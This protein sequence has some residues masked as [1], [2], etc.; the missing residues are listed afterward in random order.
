MKKYRR[1]EKYFR[2]SISHCKNINLRAETAK[3]YMEYG[4]LLNELNRPQ[5]ARK[6]WVQ[7]TQFGTVYNL[8]NR[9]RQILLL[10]F[11]GTKNDLIQDKLHI[12]GNTLKTHLKNIYSKLK[13]NSRKELLNLFMKFIEQDRITGTS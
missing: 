12:S 1:A 3:T 10:L 8:T 2:E 5:E 11:E 4:I 9:E 6:Y 7:A 13:I